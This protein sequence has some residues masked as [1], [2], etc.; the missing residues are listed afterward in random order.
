MGRS[1]KKE[2]LASL[3][4][5]TMQTINDAE[6]C[7][8]DLK[9]QHEQ[10]LESMKNAET[11]EDI[12]RYKDLEEEVQQ[13]EQQIKDIESKRLDYL[14]QNGELLFKFA[15]CSKKKQR[16]IHD[17]SILKTRSKITK[18]RASK[19]QRYY[20]LFRANIDPD[21]VYTTEQNINEDNYCF[22]CNKF[23]VLIPDEAIMVCEACGTKT[24]VVT[25]P[26]KPSMKDPPAENRYY[27]YKRYTHF[28]ECLSNLQGKE[29]TRVPDEVINAVIR[30]IKREKMEN[31]IDE[32]CEDD[33]RKYLKKYNHL[34]Y[35]H[36]YNH[37]TQILFRITDIPP[38]QM[39]SEMEQNLKL[40]F[41][42]IQ[43]P[44]EMYKAGRRNFSSY[45][46]I[47]YKLCQLLEY[48]EF[49]PKLKLHK[50]F[51]KLYEHDQ[52]WK[53]ICNHMGGEEAGWKFIK[54]YEY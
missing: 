7:L 4:R 16:Q 41:L 49:L 13:I 43:E 3:H 36:Y 39:S 5:K 10:L 11:E 40:M 50:N 48:N 23:R 27:E 51:M 52:I 24:T 17:M 37:I 32:L 9:E 29:N 54:S 8:P 2:T 47:I 31:R 38:L 1:D 14:T 26:I 12:I 28:C 46:Y 6:A 42:E 25:N 20:Q 19:K 35:D 44:F 22:D 34:K 45:A 18:K 15:E 53:K 33:I 21:Y 30:E